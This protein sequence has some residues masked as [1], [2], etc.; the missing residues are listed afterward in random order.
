MKSKSLELYGWVELRH[1]GEMFAPALTPDSTGFT[2]A[3]LPAQGVVNAYLQ[4]RVLDVRLFIR[5]EN[6]TAQEVEE[7]PG[8]VIATPRYLY[9]IKWTFTN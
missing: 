1:R 8:R 7:L 9:G 2:T 3:L 5:G 4:I 6:L